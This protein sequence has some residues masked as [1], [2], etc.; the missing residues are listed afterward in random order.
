MSNNTPLKDRTVKGVSWSAADAILGQGITFVVGIVLARILSPSEYG[1]IGICLIFTTVLNGIVDSGFSNALIRKNN[2]TQSDYN[3]MFITNMAISIVLYIILYF[4]APLVA[5][6]FNQPILTQLVR[7]MGLLLIINAFSIV[8]VTSLTKRLDFKSKTKAS[9]ISAI[10]SGII[11]ISLA[12]LNFGVWALVFQQLSRQLIYTIVLWI[13]NNWKP[14]FLFSKDS[15]Q[16]MWGFGWKMMLSGLLANIWG[17]LSQ[18][19]VG[20]FYS[21]AT[22]GQYTKS[23]EYAS[24]FSS[25]ITLIVQRVTFPVLSELQDNQ[26]RMV[27]AYRRVIKVTMF[28][29]CCSMFFLG[30]VSEP[31]INFL[32]G[33]KWYEASTYLPLICLSMSMYPLHAINLNMLQVLGRS[34]IFLKIEIVKK[35]ISILPL[36]LGIFV[37]IYAMLIANVF[38]GLLCFFLNSYYSGKRLNYS[39]WSQL[40]DVSSDYIIATC[41]AVPVF[42]VKYIGLSDWLILLIQFVLAAI[43]LVV[44]CELLHHEEYFEIKTIV[45]EFYNKRNG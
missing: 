4:V 28:V 6:F 31:L 2:V 36:C 12:Y 25:N 15:F 26:E 1:L 39:T 16:Y 44:I 17:Q 42:F 24:L 18:V 40:K 3:T 10:S 14:N 11:G 41:M 35:I 13:I 33:S 23:N 8:Q 27:M 7:A 30:S 21:S 20:K 29:T 19:V 45:K 37:N 22:L 9:L 32:I 5:V 34:D 43:I 38:T